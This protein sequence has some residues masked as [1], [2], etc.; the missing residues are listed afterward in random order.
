MDD[1]TS[2]QML[3]QVDSAETLKV[4]DAELAAL[5]T[6]VYVA[7]GYTPEEDAPSLFVPAAV[8]SRG[9]IFAVRHPRTGKLA[10]MII[11][12][13]PQS[14]ACRLGTDN[15]A[16]I[17]LLAVAPE[18]R[19]WGLARALVRSAIARAEIAGYRRVMLWTQAA[20]VAA[21]HLYQS[22]GFEQVRSYEHDGRTF[23]VYEKAL[24]GAG[25]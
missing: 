3:F 23:M 2:E 19:R 7:G 21:Q 6:Q 12:V 5:L 9:Q 20:M 17:H 25:A 16:E 24:G 14:P 15:D 4:S 1:E 10:G 8:R 22:E 13:P 18:C 11:L